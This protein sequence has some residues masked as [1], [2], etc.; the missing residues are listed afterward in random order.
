MNNSKDEV[1]ASAIYQI[2]STDTT[3]VSG[4]NF[5]EINYYISNNTRI[6]YGGNPYTKLD[7]PNIVFQ[8]SQVMENNNLPTGEYQIEIAIVLDLTEASAYTIGKRISG[9]IYDLINKKPDVLNNASSV[10]GKYLRC[11]QIYR[12]NSD[13]IEDNVNKLLRRI[14]V[15]YMQCDDEVIV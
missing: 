4:K 11:R 9:R 10:S 3:V 14:D 15:Y 5:R 2:L 8:V 1:I 13:E 7:R 6:R 12:Q